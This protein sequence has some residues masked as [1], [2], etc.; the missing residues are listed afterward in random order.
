MTQ[1]RPTI[2]E[3]KKKRK[4]EFFFELEGLSLQAGVLQKLFRNNELACAANF[5]SIFWGWRRKTVFSNAVP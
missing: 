5:N 2:S 4:P 3:K 1:E